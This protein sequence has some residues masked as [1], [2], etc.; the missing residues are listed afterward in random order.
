MISSEDYVLHL[1]DGNKI[2]LPLF[3]YDNIEDIFDNPTEVYYKGELVGTVE[4][5]EGEFND[6]VSVSINSD[7]MMFVKRILT[8]ILDY[9]INNYTHLLWQMCIVVYLFYIGRLLCL[10][11]LFQFGVNNAYIRQLVY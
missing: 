5:L 3:T 1:E 11:L 9:Q 8:D 7:E 4:V 2:K 10:K 6:F